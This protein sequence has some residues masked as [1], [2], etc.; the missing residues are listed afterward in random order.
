MI[1]SRK[2][3]VVPIKR[4]SILFFIVYALLIIRDFFGIH[5]SVYI[6]TIIISL[7]CCLFSRKEIVETG[8]FLIPLSAAINIGTI[9]GVLAIIYLFKLVR[10][11]EIRFRAPS[12]MLIVLILFELMHLLISPFSVGT[13]LAYFCT[14]IFLTVV[15]ADDRIEWI[16]KS[17]IDIFIFSV[18]VSNLLI[19]GLTMITSGGGITSLIQKAWRVG[20]TFVDEIQGD[21]LLYNNSNNIALQCCIA[22]SCLVAFY[23]TKKDRVFKIVIQMGLLTVI[24]LLTISRTFLVTIFVVIMWSIISSS[25]V[26]TNR[27]IGIIAISILGVVALFYFSPMLVNNLIFRFKTAEIS[28]S[29]SSRANII[30]YYIDYIN[31]DINSI[32]FGIGMQSH[33]LKTGYRYVA[34]NMILDIYVSWGLTG[35]ILTA[36]YF[37]SLIKQYAIKN[38]NS[39]QYITLASLLVF[40]QSGRIFKTLNVMIMFVIVV[41]IL[42]IIGTNGINE[43]IDR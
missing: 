12:Y 36:V 28:T 17:T 6:L 15:F 9:Y 13:Y 18:I 7:A 39:L 42:Q 5:Y 38:S 14:Y 29:D 3:M 37:I 11:G 34:H 33:N 8:V 22:I 19:L 21:Y 20:T 4:T 10:N 2:G 30:R 26:R 35:L 25:G 23:Q 41:C 40:T 16:S 27:K 32:L 1:N 43:E 31:R 24:G